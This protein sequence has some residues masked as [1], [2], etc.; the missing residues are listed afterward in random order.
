MKNSTRVSYMRNYGKCDFVRNSPP[1][2][3]LWCG[4]HFLLNFG[5]GL[6]YINHIISMNSCSEKKIYNIMHA[7]FKYGAKQSTINSKY[8]WSRRY[9]YH[10]PYLRCIHM[11]WHICRKYK[12]QSQIRLQKEFDH[13]VYFSSAWYIF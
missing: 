12:S 5:P 6:P 13:I 10:D 8:F 1:M 2:R 9:T 7:S 4:I 11:F 3:M